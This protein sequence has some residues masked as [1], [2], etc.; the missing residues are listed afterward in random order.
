MDHDAYFKR[1]QE[2]DSRKAEIRELEGL[3]S[4][5][6]LMIKAFSSRIE[7]LNEEIKQ[8]T[9]NQ[10]GSVVSLTV[11]LDSLDQ[12]S[13]MSLLALANDDKLIARIQPFIHKQEHNK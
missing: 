10:E 4:E 3:T 12:D 11:C 6:K 8:I 2:V 5:F 9:N 1:M 13:L 7:A